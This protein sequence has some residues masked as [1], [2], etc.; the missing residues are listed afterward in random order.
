MEQIGTYDLYLS[1]LTAVNTFQ[2]GWYRP[3]SDFQQKVNDI[4][5]ALWVKWTNEAEKSQEA[6]DNL[7]F[8]LKSKNVIAKQAKANYAIVTPPADY[9]RFATMSIITVD[10][11]TYPSLEV[12]QGKCEG[13]EWDQEQINEEY[14]ASITQNDVQLIDKMRWESCLNHPTKGP[15][16]EEPK[17][18][19]IN[20][21][22]RVAPRQVSVVVLSYYINPTPAVFAYTLAPGDRQTGAG[23]QIIFNKTG[24][25][26][27]PWPLTVKNEF[28][29]RLGEAY[30]LF[31][32]DQFVSRFSTEQKMTA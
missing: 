21:E 31:T 27:L 22:F 13:L 9:A 30:G 10:E 2:G 29:I 32:R 20:E 19:Q 8:F 6:R 12:E 3:Q 16:L 24:S 23:A 7:I 18:V 1:F 26:D 15:T 28:I 11:K 25:K 17:A 14:Y 5:L 4:S